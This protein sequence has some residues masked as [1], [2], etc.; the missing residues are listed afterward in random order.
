MGTTTPRRALTTVVLPLA[1]TA[2]LAAAVL[3]PTF[4]GASSHREAPAITED[5]TADNT[6]LYFF[7]SPDNPSTATI[8]GSWIPF[9]EPQGGPNFYAFSPNARYYLNVDKD[10]D[11]KWDLRYRYVFRTTAPRSDAAGYLYVSPT[12]QVLVQQFYTLDEETRDASGRITTRRLASGAP[13]APNNAGP[14][15][16][17]Q[18]SQLFQAAVR[19]LPGGYRSFAGQTD[20][21]FFVDLGMIFDLVNLNAPG[22]PGVGVGNQGNG[23]DSLSRYN[24]HS[25]ALQVPISKLRGRTSVVG[26]YASTERPYTAAETVTR[27]VRG[28]RVKTQRLVTKYRQVSRLG[29]PLINEVIIPRYLKDQWNSEEPAT[30]RKYL[31][32]YTNTF[33]GGALNA[34]FPS[35]GLNIPTTGRQDIS[36]AL[37][38]GLPGLNNTG[39]TPADLLRLN[40]DTPVSASPQPLG[41]LQGDAQGFPN[42][43][44]LADDVVDIE[45]RVI[46]GALFNLAGGTANKLPLGDGVTQNDKPF[47]NTF[48][49]LAQPADGFF[50][51]PPPHNQVNPPVTPVGPLP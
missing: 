3:I 32:Y 35:L 27:T 38:N 33:V 4:G 28:V 18:Y 46:G 44:R 2:A 7:R 43:R 11:G 50:T 10:G 13:T 1:A 30:D 21:P 6:D 22:R 24:V 23:V 51:T 8:I 41:P 20:D 40:L 5:P 12:N 48:P 9:E 49:Y 17:P 29:N 45:L 34:L 26:V 15:S 16:L 19:S 37:L 42:G 25:I 36:T 39:R 31:R 14:K 47:S